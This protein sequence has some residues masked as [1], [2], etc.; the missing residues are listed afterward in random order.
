M[1]EVLHYTE[2]CQKYKYTL[3]V[4]LLSR[5]PYYIFAEIETYQEKKDGTKKPWF[6]VEAQ[7]TWAE[8]GGRA[9]FEAQATG[10]PVPTFKW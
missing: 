9:T 8:V 6:V 4:T 5:T 10:A 2:G 1:K 3:K 7:N